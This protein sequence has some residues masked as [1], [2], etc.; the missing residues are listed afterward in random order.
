[1]GLVLAAGLALAGVMLSL[2]A[3]QFARFQSEIVSRVLPRRYWV[4]ASDPNVVRVAGVVAT[5]VAVAIGLVVV[6][7][8]IL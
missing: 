2:F 7:P 5:L 3:S 8:F 4:F 1:M 6:A